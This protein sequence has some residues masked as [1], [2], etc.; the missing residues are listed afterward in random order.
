LEGSYAQAAGMKE[1]DMTREQQRQ[2]Y[3]QMA[4]GEEG[5][6]RLAGAETGIRATDAGRKAGYEDASMLSQVGADIEGRDQNGS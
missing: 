1:K 6:L 3:N 4:T 5:K 2:R